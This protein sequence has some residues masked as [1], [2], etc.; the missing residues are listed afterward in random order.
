MSVLT[1]MMQQYR[2][3]KERFPEEILFFRLG[4]FYEMF[5]DDAL[6]ASEIL[7]IALTARDGGGGKKVPMCGVPH[8]SA[9][10]YIARLVARGC[11]VAIAEQMEDPSQAKGLVSREVVR[12]ITPGTLTEEG[13][14][15]ERSN[16][17]IVGVSLRENMVGIASADLST[18]YFGVSW[19]SRL[20]GLHN[21]NDELGRLLPAEIVTETA[22]PD[23]QLDALLD[24]SATVITRR[25][26]PEDSSL[27]R[28]EEMALR[29]EGMPSAGYR[30][31]LQAGALLMEYLEE[32]QKQALVNFQQVELYT[33]DAFM[34]MDRQTRRNLEISQSLREGD[35][36]TSLVHILD[37]TAT[38]MGG[39]L[40]RRWLEQPL[41]DL[42]AITRRQDAVQELT[43][44]VFLREDLRKE[45]KR[46]YDLERILTRVTL[47]RAGARDLRAMAQ[48]LMAAA[49]VRDLLAAQSRI[50]REEAEQLDVLPDLTDLLDRGIVEEPPLSVKEGN[51]IREGY[52]EEIDGLRE[53]ASMGRR[54][55]S[56]LEERERE[57]TGIR[58]LKVG[59]N[60]VFGYY[61]EVSKSHRDKVPEHYQRKQTL[62]GGE[63]FITPEL[64]ELEDRVLNASDR[65]VRREYE[66]F[67]G[68]RQ[69]AAGRA[70]G[71]QVLAGFLASLDVFGSFAAAAVRF[72][73]VR[74]RLDG[75]TGL[76]VRQGRHPVV[77]RLLPEGEFIPNDCTL[78][79]GQKSLGILTGP[80]MAGKSTY[81]RMV[82]VLTVMAQSGSFVPARSMEL[83]L[84]DR[85]FARVGAS[86]DLATGQST[87]M[88]EMNEVANI[89]KNATASSLI[90]LDEVGRGTSTTDGLAIAWS[91]SEY[92][93]SVTGARTLFATHYHELVALEELYEGIFNL[94]M[95]VRETG[96]QV[97]FLRRVIPGGSDRSYGIHVARMAGLPRPVLT[98]AEEKLEE[99]ETTRE[100][101]VLV[102]GGRQLE[103][104]REN[105]VVDI[106]RET[107]LD[108]FTPRQ[109]LDFLYELKEMA[110]KQED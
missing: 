16:N 29:P 77:E 72:G 60:R 50:F 24:G 110:L 102:Q 62:A 103:I 61:L 96:D 82:A 81:I 98:R 59:Y 44:N 17:Y 94:S 27:A 66:L 13:A 109:A 41:I 53:T 40:L 108:D 35:R 32:T 11:K 38:A 91:V 104:L 48:S 49:R 33:L 8:H 75:G 51:L 56:E 69:E 65:L 26:G 23:R 18:G 86:D 4:D 12:I 87:F 64:K 25:Q 57:A 67:C 80:N 21:L 79:A 84:A 89:L 7:E 2:S 22:K 99:L 97:L 47:G 10:G 30:A 73:Y 105:P 71:L 93:H 54:W 101:G 6:K 31:A 34:Y 1:P 92:I 68:I 90:I 55:I 19:I 45:L 83:G 42:E 70:R 20:A 15:P 9:E 106:L 28:L 3:I 5:F 46:V 74:P 52:S 76:S 36:K 100:T 78:S 95:D 85:V 107:V 88:V 58:T 14:L 39:R 43:E 63:R 37:F